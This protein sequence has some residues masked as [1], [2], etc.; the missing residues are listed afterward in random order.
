M[1]RLLRKNNTNARILIN[2]F[3]KEKGY[4]WC[5]GA[6]NSNY[7]VFCYAPCVAGAEYEQVGPYALYKD[8]MMTKIFQRICAE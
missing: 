3:M 5:Y 1:K 8:V 6:S 2:Y 7:A 4:G